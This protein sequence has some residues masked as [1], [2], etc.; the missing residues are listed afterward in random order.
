MHE[1]APLERQPHLP[2]RLSVVE[3]RPYVGVQ[4]VENLGRV[5][6][7]ILVHSTQ[8]EEVWVVLAVERLA[9]VDGELVDLLLQHTEE[10]FDS[11]TVLAWRSDFD[12][13]HESEVLVLV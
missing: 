7:L 12:L 11:S 10:P 6:D 8:V 2:L 9:P 5:H 1:D 13:E 3:Q 4:L